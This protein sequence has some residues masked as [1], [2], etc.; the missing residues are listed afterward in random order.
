MCLWIHMLH[1]VFIL[2]YEHMFIVAQLAKLAAVGGEEPD[3]QN[4][5]LLAIKT[6][7]ILR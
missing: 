7:P 6:D 3:T 4:T 5:D 1:L 2:P